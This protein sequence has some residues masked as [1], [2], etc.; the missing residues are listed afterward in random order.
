MT[1]RVR[2]TWWRRERL[3]VLLLPLILVGAIAATSSRVHDFWWVKDFRSEAPV[4]AAG[5]AT[6]DLQYDDG[7]L[8]YPI[9]ARVSLESASPVSQLPEADAPV[10]IPTGSRLWLV[11]LAWTADP[12]VA[13]RDCR[14]ALV[15]GDGNRY[16]STVNAFEANAPIA[17][18]ACVPDETPGPVPRFGSAEAP[19]VEPG[20][21]PRP[22]SYSTTAYVL[23]PED[24]EPV[25]ARVWWILPDYVD[26]PIS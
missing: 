9:R 24:V 15:D 26:L 22:E 14:V 19:A 4:D 1:S 8:T 2:R 17:Y 5:V 3:A 12:D 23:L 21:Q 16:D 10:R 13:L 11:G 25:A 18:N 6:V 20:Q 7:F